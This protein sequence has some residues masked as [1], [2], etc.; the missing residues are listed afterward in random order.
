MLRQIADQ[1]DK[2]KQHIFYIIQ[3]RVISFNHYVDTGSSFLT[4]KS[5]FK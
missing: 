5:F 3:L 1:R 4:S 2:R